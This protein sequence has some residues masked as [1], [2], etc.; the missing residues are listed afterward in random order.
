MNK[1][2]SLQINAINSFFNSCNNGK[3]APFCYFAMLHYWLNMKEIAFLCECNYLCKINKRYCCS[4]KSNVLFHCPKCFVKKC[5]HCRRL[6]RFN[7]LLS[8]VALNCT[9]KFKNYFLNLWNH[10]VKFK[11][12]YCIEPLRKNNSCIHTCLIPE[13]IDV[14]Y[15]E[16]SYNAFTTRYFTHP[17]LLNDYNLESIMCC[18][19]I[20]LTS[21]NLLKL[22]NLMFYSDSKFRDFEVENKVY[23]KNIPNFLSFLCNIWRTTDSITLMDYFMYIL[24]FRTNNLN[25][26][27]NFRWKLL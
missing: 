25:F 27:I 20:H 26:F 7:F 5:R 16:E 1:I 11:R 21:Q 8:H 14:R 22:Y 6:E 2:K 12:Y 3:N 4:T 17:F 19:K 15:N 13:A 24:P 9:F 18:N 10:V 23:S